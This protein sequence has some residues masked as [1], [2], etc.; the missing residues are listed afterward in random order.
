ME[1]LSE[2]EEIV[3][4]CIW[5][6][7]TGLGLSDV[8]QA[9]VAWGKTWKPQTVSTFLARLVEKGYL[10]SHRQGRSYIYTAKVGQEAYLDAQMSSIVNFWGKKSVGA[11]MS[12]FGRSKALSRDDL[13]ELRDFLDEL[14]E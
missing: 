7:P 2:S 12:A 13:K 14:D 1:K 10:E 4:R 6:A 11:L 8:I 3:M 9:C 5:D